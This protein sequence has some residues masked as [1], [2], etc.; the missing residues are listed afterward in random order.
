MLFL[1]VIY[2]ASNLILL[3]FAY[4]KAIGHKIALLA[5]K[6][7]SLANCLFYVLVGLPLLIVAQVTDYYTFLRVSYSTRKRYQSDEVFAISLKQFNKIHRVLLEANGKHIDIK[8][9]DLVLFVREE[10]FQVQSN[11]TV[12][13][14]GMTKTETLKKFEGD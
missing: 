4:L 11:I 8:A 3:P 12:S 5:K 13:I 7:I 9:N 14:Y 2:I 6:R 10:I 1:S